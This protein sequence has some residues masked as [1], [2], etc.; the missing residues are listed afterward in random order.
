MTSESKIPL[1]GRIRVDFSGKVDPLRSDQLLLGEPLPT[2]NATLGFGID[3]ALESKAKQV[4]SSQINSYYTFGIG[5][6]V[7]LYYFAT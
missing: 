4:Y 5:M 2:W 1:V 7:V 6:L 3:S